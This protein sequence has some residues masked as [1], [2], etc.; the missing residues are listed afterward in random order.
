[1]TQ[2]HSEPVQQLPSKNPASPLKQAP[3][4]QQSH[5]LLEAAHEEKKVLESN[6]E[7]SEDKAPTHAAMEG[8]V[9]EGPKR[10]HLAFVN[11]DIYQ[12]A[13]L[14]KMVPPMYRI[15]VVDIVQRNYEQKMQQQKRQ[16]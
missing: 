12:A 5:I 7:V 14:N 6:N 8:T 9:G 4:H 2:H 15:D 13:I 11:A 3:Q 16:R 10:G 1:M